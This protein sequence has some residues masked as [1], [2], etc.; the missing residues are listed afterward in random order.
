MRRRAASR[1][2]DSRGGQIPQIP[3]N[4]L[5]V[6]NV[7]VIGLYWGYYMGVGAPAAAGRHGR[8]S[9]RRLRRDAGLDGTKA[10]CARIPGA[11][12][13]VDAFRDALAAISTREVIGR[14]V[15]NLVKVRPGGR[16]PNMPIGLHATGKRFSKQKRRT[17]RDA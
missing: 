17:R 11:A 4:I 2:W 1:P 3:A 10:A 6:K 13:H 7:T 15:L 12:I 5:L 9:A 8:H 16:S 14:V